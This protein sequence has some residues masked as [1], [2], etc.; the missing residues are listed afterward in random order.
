M[1][2]TI[3]AISTPVGVGG[4]SVIRISGSNAFSVA[5]SMFKSKTP[6]E[7]IKSHTVT[8]GTVQ[9][10]KGNTLDH[11]LLLKMQAPKTYTGEDTVEIH[12]HG[13]IY[14]TKKILA[15]AYA[16]GAH[17]AQPGEFTKRAFVN[18]HIDLMEA[19]AVMDLINS[20]AE[21]TYKEALSQMKGEKSLQIKG[22]RSELIDLISHIMVMMDYPEYDVEKITAKDTKE[23]AEEIAKRLRI[24]IE[25]FDNRRIIREG[26]NVAVVG[27]VNVGKSTFINR[28]CGQNRVIVTDI[29]GTTRDVVEVK[30]DIKGLCVILKDT[31]GIR[32]TDNEI[33]KIGIEKSKEAIEESDAVI[34]IA[35]INR[36]YKDEIFNYIKDMNKAICVL[37]KTD[38]LLENERDKHIKFMERDLK[39]IFKDRIIACSLDK[40]EGIN[41]IFDKLLDMVNAG[42]IRQKDSVITNERHKK[43]IAD[44]IKYL[45]NTKEGSFID[46]LSVD[47][48]CAAEELG[49]ITGE[50]ASADIVDRI[51]EKFCIGK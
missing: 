37:N 34:Y 51:F 42:S 25:D 10:E 48:T 32:S 23:K 3:A 29:A 31:A 49:K 12:C 47:L 18:G 24:L 36:P 40:K 30:I 15:M 16:N 4:I 21:D 13:G 28:A 19:E 38:L 5:K 35:D 22:I 17:P 6:F 26:L 43:H 41:E 1:E 2:H 14:V 44:A 45:E 11:V 7:S 46:M 27:D 20:E 39:K 9:D 50:T 33:E 8:Y